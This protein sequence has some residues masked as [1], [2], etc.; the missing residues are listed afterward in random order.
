VLVDLNSSNG[1]TGTLAGMQGHVTATWAGQG[2][3][4]HVCEAVNRGLCAP[5]LVATVLYLQASAAALWLAVQSLQGLCVL[6][7]I[8]EAA[9]VSCFSLVPASLAG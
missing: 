6:R 9:G 5:N 2:R 4:T 3:Y 1:V 8:C 7:G